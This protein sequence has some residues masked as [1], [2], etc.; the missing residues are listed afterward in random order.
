MRLKE[1]RKLTRKGD[2]ETD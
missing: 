2:M 1:Q